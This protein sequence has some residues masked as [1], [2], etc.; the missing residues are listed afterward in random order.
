MV[1]FFNKVN[2]AFHDRSLDE[3]TF[4]VSLTGSISLSPSLFLTLFHVHI[5]Q[6]N[7]RKKHT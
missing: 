5:G 3:V 6:N 1:E 2:T 4:D 7:L